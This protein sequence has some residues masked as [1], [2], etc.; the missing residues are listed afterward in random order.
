LQ[1][2]NYGLNAQFWAN[3]QY[4]DFQFSLLNTKLNHSPPV[5]LTFFHQLAA[6]SGIDVVAVIKSWRRGEPGAME[7]RTHV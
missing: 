4:S 5:E 7:D 3:R 2:I 1:S 6:T